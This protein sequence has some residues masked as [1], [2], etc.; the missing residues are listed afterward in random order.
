MKFL[1]SEKQKPLDLVITSIEKQF[2]KGFIMK[3][4]DQNSLFDKI[5]VFS[6][7]GLWV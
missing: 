2:G 3:L 5:P 6:T 1:M 4:G 7:L